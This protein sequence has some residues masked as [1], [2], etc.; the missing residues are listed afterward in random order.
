M[1]QTS[2]DIRCAALSLGFDACGVAAAEPVDDG[3]AAAFRRWVE[4]GNHAGMEWLARNTDKR[5][6]P[7]LLVPGC[8]SLIVCALSYLPKKPLTESLRPAFYA[9]GRDYH[10][11]MKAKLYELAK[12]VLSTDECLRVFVDSAP[13]LERYWAWRAGLGWLGRHHQLVVP[14]SGS[15]CFLGV[16]ATSLVL[17]PGVPMASRCGSCRECVK[18]CPTHA[19]SLP[20]EPSLPSADPLPP[21][22]SFDARRCLSYLS[23]EHRGPFTDDQRRCMALASTGCLCGCDA[24][25]LACPHN[26]SAHSTEEIAF[27]PT[28]FLASRTAAE[29]ASLTADEYDRYLRGTALARAGYEGLRRNAQAYLDV[30]HHPDSN[31]PSS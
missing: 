31:S 3:V 18:A 12:N 20:D 2:S 22:A 11:V 21:F 15:F 8:R 5:L 30:C 19:L 4:E 23:I 14:G 6:D 17:D 26:H 24:C 25:Q 10:E 29:W 9:Y 16:I 28:P 1:K 7:T 27:A 13:L